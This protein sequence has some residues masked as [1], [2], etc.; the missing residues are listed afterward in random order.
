[1]HYLPWKTFSEHQV[2]WPCLWLSCL[3][4]LRSKSWEEYKDK[5]WTGGERR[6]EDRQGLR[7]VKN[8]LL[9][10]QILGTWS[11]IPWWKFGG[12]SGIDLRIIQNQKQ[13]SQLTYPL[14][15]ICH[16]LNGAHLGINCL[17]CYFCWPRVLSLARGEKGVLRHR[18]SQASELNS[19]SFGW[20]R[21]ESRRCVQGKNSNSS[22]DK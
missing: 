14:L 22:I 7:P 19:L 10:Q 21:W 17:A 3:E 4:S 20:G 6:G 15:R 2:L 5:K 18:E 16:G 12:Q 11:L 8:L 13:G 1:M 9:N